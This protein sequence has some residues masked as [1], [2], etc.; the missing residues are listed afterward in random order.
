MWNRF[1]RF[2]LVL[3]LLLAAPFARATTLTGQVKDNQGSALTINGQIWFVISGNGNVSAGGGCG[4][5][6]QI[7][8]GTPA[9]F[10][11]TS[12]TIAGGA[13]VVGNDCISPTNT[14]YRETV[15]NSD[16]SVVLTRS[17]SVT[18]ASADIGTL[19]IASPPGGG[20]AS[21]VPSSRLI[22]TASP[23]AGGGDMSSDRTLSVSTSPG[24]AATLVGTTRSIT[25][26]SG[27][28]GGGDLSADRSFSISASAITDAMLAVPYV[29]A[30]GTRALTGN[31]NAGSSSITSGN[32]LSWVNVAKLAGVTGTGASG[33]P[34]V[35]WDTQLTAA[36]TIYYFPG[37]YYDFNPFTLSQLDQRIVGDLQ[38][39]TVLRCLSSNVSCITISGT[40]DFIE[41]VDLNL[42]TGLTPGSSDR[43][44]DIT[45]ASNQIYIRD[46]RF[47]NFWE[48]LHNEGT[49]GVNAQRLIFFNANNG[50][51]SM[52][53][54]NANSFTCEDCTSPA[55]H[56]QGFYFIEGTTSAPDTMLCTRC[57]IGIHPAATLAAQSYSNGA[58]SI[59]VSNATGI[60]I[61]LGV[62]SSV[63]GVPAGTTVTNVVGL[64][65]SISTTLSAN[66]VGTATLTFGPVNYNGVSITAAGASTAAEWVEFTDSLFECPRTDD[67]ATTTNCID[68]QAAR[69]VSFKGGYSLG[70]RNSVKIGTTGTFNGPGPVKFE[71]FLTFGSLRAGVQHDASVPTTFSDCT[72]T[73]SSQTSSAF[74]TLVLLSNSRKLA[75]RGSHVTQGILPSFVNGPQN[76]VQIVAGADEFYIGDDNKLDPGTVG[77]MTGVYPAIASA[78]TIGPKTAHVNV[79]GAVTITTITRSTATWGDVLY[80]IKPAGATWAL[81]TGGNIAVAKTPGVG[82]VT[83]LRW[84]NA[85]SLWYVE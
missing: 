77:I 44:I 73:D 50:G 29:K 56:N 49:A 13:S 14:F 2:A 3:G 48:A 6:F 63:A 33:T 46:I 57:G 7:G 60:S 79:T 17:V 51:W 62:T 39:K 65:V 26:G 31:W 45:N 71:H 1:T 34:Y 21:G 22:N 52:H 59:T 32:S 75:L 80:L 16:G 76:A 85:G 66:A 20:G 42:K 61:G 4:G 37:G 53:A 67:T 10:A 38:F 68:I 81:N 35:G 12:G 78:A 19:P 41:G 9:V 74:N 83:V 43:L 84:D 47:S 54:K 24:G 28:A 58:T 72:L 23:L 27:L 40:L 82:S 64:V 25:A 18:G 55:T 36:S 11:I 5:P 70:G 30:D 69:N 8:P 15:V